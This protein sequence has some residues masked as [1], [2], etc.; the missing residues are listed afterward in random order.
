MAEDNQSRQPTQTDIRITLYANGY[1]PLPNRDKRC[2]L[3]GWSDANYKRKWLDSGR[4]EPAVKIARME[5]LLPQD[6][7]TGLRVQ[8]GLLPI[9]LDIRDGEMLDRVLEELR[10]IAPDVHDLAPRRTG[11]APKVMLF[12]RWVPSGA[13]PEM[14]TKISSHRFVAPGDTKGQLIEV[15]GGASNKKGGHGQQVG[16]YG[17]HSHVDPDDPSKGVARTYSWDSDRN[18]ELSS[19]LNT[20]LAQLPAM[21][22]EQV[23]ALTDAFERLATAAGWAPEV[24]D[25]GDAGEGGRVYDIDESTRF[26]LDKGGEPIDYAQLCAIY[27]PRTELRVNML[28]GSDPTR[29]IVHW[30]N[31]AQCVWVWD[32]RDSKG[33]WPKSAAPA[34]PAAFAEQ[35]AAILP[36]PPAENGPPPRPDDR[37]S[38]GNKV[39]WLLATR[40]YCEQTDRVIELYKAGSDCQT[41]RIA[42]QFAHRAWHIETEGPRG[43]K[44]LAYATSGWELNAGRPALE[45]VRLRPDQPFPLYAEGGLLYKNTY[46]RLRHEGTGDIGV[47]DRF[48][49]HLLP[50]EAERSWFLNWLA[51][52]LRFPGIPGVAVI[53]VAAN[54]QGPVYG[55]GRGMLRD[56]LARL[57]GEQYVW[58]IDFDIFAGKSAQAAYTDWAAYS[59]LVTVSE[60][61]DTAESGRWA[62]RRATYE[63]LK[64][65]VDPRP[66]ER[67]F[68]PK[69]LPAFKAR[70]VASYLIF[71]NNFDAV[72]LPPDDRRAT[73]LR[74]GVQMPSAMAEELQ[75]WMN[76]PGNIAEV[77]RHLMARDL[78]AFNVYAPML[79]ETKTRMQELARSD[80][81]IAFEHVQR[82][83]GPTAL[84]TGEMIRMAVLGELDHITEA[85]EAQIRQ[86]VKNSTQKVPGEHRMPRAASLGKRHWILGWHGGPQGVVLSSDEAVLRVE[87]AAKLLETLR[88]GTSLGAQVIDFRK[89]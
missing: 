5:M 52:K 55:A 20:P 79:T 19:P 81:D 16:A 72:Q 7:A 50:E 85:I 22:K 57:F 82:A 8:D 53:M 46:Q 67:M 42:F 30:S 14:F 51:H 32:W 31:A 64:E 18:D 15:F 29:C 9:D 56:V 54:A 65:T 73:V 88:D 24:R 39:A 60:A 1:T 47:W 80:L 25:E 74:N 27:D 35:M 4:S 87:H 75:T 58:T 38:I 78:R 48:M 11:E 26:Q 40:G 34:D 3:G 36:E 13:H 28:P 43:G 76:Q 59:L 6:K 37:A 21:T 70:A 17:P 44:K 45:G 77:A 41:T 68:T 63:R 12:A 2:L 69:G 84:F 10:R 23:F 89:G 86:K 62:D 61:K 49:A 66:V 83:L 33:H 71:S